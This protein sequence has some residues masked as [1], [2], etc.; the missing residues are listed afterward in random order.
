[1]MNRSDKFPPLHWGCLF[2]LILLQP[3][4][5]QADTYYVAIN[6]NDSNPGTLD[7]P[8][9]HPQRCVDPGS[10]LRAG[11]VC[12]IG[13]GTYSDADG[14]GITVYIR[15]TA[16]SGTPSQPITL[17]SEIP[18][19]AV[20][21]IPS[22]A[23]PNAGIH[24][25]RSYYVIE[26]FDLT[27]G[28]G[29][30]ATTAINVSYVD[31]V[32]IRKNMIHHIGWGACADHANSYSG[33]LVRSANDILIED[34]TY[35][36]I[37]RL[38]NGE[39]GCTTI[40]YQHDHGIY[41]SATSNLTVRRNVFYEITRGYPFQVY[42]AKGEPNRNVV[43]VHNVI[44]GKSPTGNPVGQIVLCNP[45]TNVQIKN[46]IFYDPPLDYAIH[47]CAAG[48]TASG[49]AISHNLTNGT[50]SDFQTPDRKPLS[51]VIYSNNKTN[52]DPRFVD[53][54]SHDY[55]LRSTSPAINSGANV[56]L[57]YKGSAPDIG[58]FE[59]SEQND[60]KPLRPIL[61]IQ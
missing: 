17:R 9:H 59:F 26:G 12:S 23:T 37:G 35:H 56:G 3:L 14:D 25:S 47:Y 8:W 53:A 31:G 34:N 54:G 13:P 1:M 22:L 58:A 18:L 60:E 30:A 11:D 5:A 27:G 6:G 28:T 15:T 2:L 29:A 21:T 40:R 48:A 42:N 50:R 45:L 4:R 43:F 19:E 52:I 44:S 10:P 16:P 61:N 20:I 46:N 55:K 33:T 51:G 24:V 57:P 32:T 36:H 7:Q 38:R 49:L 39:S 41:D